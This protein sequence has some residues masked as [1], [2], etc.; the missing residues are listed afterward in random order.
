[1][2]ISKSLGKYTAWYFLSSLPYYRIFRGIGIQC[3]QL[4]CIVWF[5][6]FTAVKAIIVDWMNVTCCLLTDWWIIYI[7]WFVSLLVLCSCY[8]AKMTSHIITTVFDGYLLPMLP[9]LFPW[10]VPLFT[11]VSFIINTIFI[12]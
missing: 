2:G 5:Y 7:L 11:T 12:R 6:F 10:N 3:T 9:K 8:V 1:M 4:F